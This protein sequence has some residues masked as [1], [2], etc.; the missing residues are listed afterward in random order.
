MG[1][2]IGK[3]KHCIIKSF[4]MMLISLIKEHGKLMKWFV[5]WVEFVHF[6]HNITLIYPGD[7]TI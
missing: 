5:H 1:I 2:K 3:E 6:Q 7:K 4:S